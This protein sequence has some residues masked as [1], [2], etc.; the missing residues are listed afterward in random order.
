M[1]GLYDYIDNLEKNE[2][3]DVLDAVL[4]RYRELYPQWDISL[5]TVDKREDKNEQLDA[6][7]QMLQN[8]KV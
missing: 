4:F 5:I 3:G 6:V 7:I 1:M 2:I 8:M